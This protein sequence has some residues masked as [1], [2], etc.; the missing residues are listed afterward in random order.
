M[1]SPPKISTLKSTEEREAYSAQH[2]T[3]PFCDS[4]EGI[5]VCNCR[6][7]HLLVDTRSFQVWAMVNSAAVNLGIQVIV[8]TEFWGPSGRWPEVKLLCNS[9]TPFLVF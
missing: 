4:W 2:V 5:T 1:V 9:E 3:V 6:Y 7:G 8:G